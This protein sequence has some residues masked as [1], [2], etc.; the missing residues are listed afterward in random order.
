MPVQ[1][2]E[3]KPLKLNL[4]YFADQGNQGDT[5]QD[6]TGADN[7][8]DTQHPSD[9]DNQSG[10][11]D[12]SKT[13]SEDYVKDLRSEA[14]KYRTKAKELETQSQS[15]QQETIK[16]MFEALGIDPDPNKELDKQLSDAQTKAQ[17]AERKANDKLI[18]SE[19][20]S[21]GV[22]LNLVDPEAA[23]V[24][25]DKE[26]FKVNDDGSVEG[27]RESLEKLLEEKPYLKQV[28]TETKSAYQPGAT[29]KSNANTKDQDPR[30]MGA[31]LAAARHKK[32][33]DE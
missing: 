30:A 29:Q 2:K 6:S 31:A 22:D 8:G 3:M 17:E 5:N 21:I 4:Q 27:V 19:I 32:E 25:A 11:T 9:N 10:N 12:D 15:Q 13:F 14:A 7:Q 16:K 23:Y 33:D 28:E 18:R 1:N 26:G 24:L 20:K